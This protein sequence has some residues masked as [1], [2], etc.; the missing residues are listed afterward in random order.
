MATKT[1]T[2]A[3]VAAAIQKNGWAKVTG[4]YVKTD[5]DGR[6]V[7]GCAIGQGAVNLGVT[8][9][10]LKAA[11]DQLMVF[12]GESLIP[13]KLGDW[14]TNRNDNNKDLS[15]GEIGRLAARRLN[16]IG[17]MPVVLTLESYKTS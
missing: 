4:T 10:S 13:M 1:V 11:L 7:G 16:A 3:E 14:V 9:T 6:V 15:V 2:L 5:K 17:Q 12:D 8:Y